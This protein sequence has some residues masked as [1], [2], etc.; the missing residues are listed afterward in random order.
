MHALASVDVTHVQYSSPIC[1]SK[2]TLF[3]HH[4][5]HG[6]LC[7]THLGDFE[8]SSSGPDVFFLHLIRPVDN[9]STGST[10]QTVAISLLDA[11]HHGDVRLDHPTK[12]YSPLFDV[13]KPQINYLGQKM[14]RQVRDAFLS[15]NDVRL[16]PDDFLAD[17]LDVL[18]FQLE[19]TSEVFFFADLDVRLPT[20]ESI[21][22][23]IPF[24]HDSVIDLRRSRPSCTP[25]CSQAGVPWGFRSCGASCSE[26]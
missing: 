3:D 15:E 8:Q 17:L 20:G 6:S 26:T 21:Q 16:H 5:S 25:N 13:A 23:G 2:R 12:S 24:N 4:N 19:V 22:W 10:R 11:P 1:K 18:L 14:L 7:S 9:C